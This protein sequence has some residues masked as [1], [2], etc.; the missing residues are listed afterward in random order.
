[1]YEKNRQTKNQNNKNLKINLIKISK[2]T[3]LTVIKHCWEK[4]NAS[5]K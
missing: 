4:L 2:S 3:N 1:M 5:V